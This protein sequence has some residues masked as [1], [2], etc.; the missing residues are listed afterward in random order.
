LMARNIF[1]EA[2]AEEKEALQK[3]LSEDPAIQQQY[4]ILLQTLQKK[5]Q[6]VMQNGQLDKNVAKI[7]RKASLQS[8]KPQK[9]AKKRPIL[10]WMSAAAA[11]FLLCLGAW[12]FLSGNETI[13]TPPAQKPVLTAKNGN[14]NQMILPDG[15]KVWLN[16]GSELFYEN[17]FKGNTREVRLKGEAFFDVKKNPDRPF[18]V[19]ANNIDIKVLGTAFNVK[20]YQDDENV[21]T[22]LYRGLVN[23]SK[24]DDNSFQPILLYPNQKLILPRAIHSKIETVKVA[25]ASVKNSI[26]IKQIDSTK[27]EPLRIETAWIYN[28]LEFRG[29]DFATLASK[30]ERWYNVKINF[31]DTQVQKL[32]FNGSFEKET[33]EQALKALKTANSFNYK[34]N[35]NEILISSSK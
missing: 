3:Y 20:A 29:D 34:M 25:A 30:L 27:A 2:S 35:N 21:E 4:S 18:I 9:S 6:P 14:R 13:I 24:S 31:G 32:N 33:V 28:R 17:D 19:H 22:T 7:I 23:V 1:G 11:V 26:I 15:S 10:Y 5:D 12:W 8:N 16:A